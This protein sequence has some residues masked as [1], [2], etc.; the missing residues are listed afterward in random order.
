MTDWRQTVGNKSDPMS[1]V[2]TGASISAGKV[3]LT[4]IS[5]SPDEV[6]PGGLVQLDLKFENNAGFI[7]PIDPALCNPSGISSEGLEIEVSASPSWGREKS[8]RA[9]V[10]NPFFGGGG[11]YDMS[12]TFTAPDIPAQDGP[13]NEQINVSFRQVGK[14]SV[15]SST[16]A[17]VTVSTAGRESP[18]RD[19]GTGVGSGFNLQ[20]FVVENPITAGAAGVAGIVFVRTATETAIGGD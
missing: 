3:V 10:S 17:N 15:S 20:E 8:Q 18:R 2:Q 13:S 9:C 4:E 14:D 7:S 1:G 16:Y 11:V 6:S 5:V 19:D 12:F